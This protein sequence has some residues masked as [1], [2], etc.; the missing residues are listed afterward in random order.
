MRLCC[1]YSLDMPEEDNK[2]EDTKDKKDK[3]AESEKKPFDSLDLKK[4]LVFGGR[5][6]AS[7]TVLAE[8]A[9]T[10]GWRGVSQRALEE[11]LARAVDSCY[12]R[13]VSFE[14][15]DLDS[16]IPWHASFLNSRGLW[17][18]EISSSPRA[19]VEPVQLADFFSSELFRKIAK[20]AGWTLE[21]AKHLLEDVISPLL[22]SGQLLKVDEVKLAAIEHWLSDKQFMENLRSGKFMEA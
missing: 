20:R 19:E 7:W 10:L 9:K 17:E 13:L 21:E 16:E 6:K 22:E 14:A 1:K 8:Q 11:S 4:I 5:G 3:A 2:T 18:L 15:V 12:F